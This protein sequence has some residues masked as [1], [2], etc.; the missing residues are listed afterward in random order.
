MINYP[1]S[2]PSETMGHKFLLAFFM[3]KS[4]TPAIRSRSFAFHVGP[5]LS[6]PIQPPCWSPGWRCQ[7]RC[8]IMSPWR[9]A[10]WHRHI[11]HPVC[12][13]VR[14]VSELSSRLSHQLALLVHP[15]VA[16]SLSLSG[17][18]SILSLYFMCVHFSYHIDRMTIILSGRGAER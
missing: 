2:P 5:T 9:P 7:S 18:G 11:M 15:S 10:D 6:I 12:Q 16:L 8:C 1:V 17:F 14:W 4:F 13:L 3:S